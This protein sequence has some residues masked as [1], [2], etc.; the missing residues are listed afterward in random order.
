[1]DALRIIEALHLEPHP[2]GGMYAE[3]WRADATDGATTVRDCDLLPVARGRTLALASRRRRRDLALLRGRRARAADERGRTFRRT[4]RASVPTSPPANGRS[5]SWPRTRGRPR[6][7]WAHGRWW[8]ARCRPASSSTGS[9]SHHRPGN[10]P[11]PDLT[12]ADVHVRFDASAEPRIS[13]TN[14]DLVRLAGSRG[15]ISDAADRR[16]RSPPR[17]SGAAWRRSASRWR[18]TSRAPRPRR[19]STSRTSA[20][21]RSSTRQGRLAALSVGIPQFMLTS[22]LPVRFALEFL[23]V[24]EFR[25]GDV[26]VANDPYHGGGHLPDY[27]VFAPVLRR[28]PGHRRRG[29]W[30]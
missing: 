16:S 27:N 18:S 6:N 29:A 21:P 25:E 4:P 20:T 13:M 15:R 17:S 24:D 26:F 9:S 3:T 12:S 7:R 19:S 8:A 23:G 2:E 28:R 30:C 10:R 5:W 1:M 11:E 22:T 14:V